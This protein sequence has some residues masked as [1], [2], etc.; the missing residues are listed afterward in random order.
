MGESIQRPNIQVMQSLL[1][2]VSKGDPEHPDVSLN[3]ED[4]WAL[5][6]QPSQTLIFEN[7][8]TG[9]G[10]WHLKEISPE[11]ALSFWEQLSQGLMSELKNQDWIAGYGN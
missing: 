3:I 9:E 11:A 2:S 7:V 8:E 6:Y 5:S 1:A 10:P 4:G